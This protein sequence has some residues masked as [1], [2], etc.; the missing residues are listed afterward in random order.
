MINKHFFVAKEDEEATE[1]EEEKCFKL[2]NER[3]TLMINGI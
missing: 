1:E 3:I 2:N